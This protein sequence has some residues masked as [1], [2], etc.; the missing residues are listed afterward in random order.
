MG[1]RD[2]VVVRIR[3]NEDGSRVDLRSS[4]R[5]G[6]F[7]FGTNAARVRSLMDDIDDAIG[8]QKPDQPASPVPKKKAPPKGGQG[9]AKR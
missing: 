8:A 5:Y 6:A 4:S 3:P 1:F 7:D 9:T 2:D